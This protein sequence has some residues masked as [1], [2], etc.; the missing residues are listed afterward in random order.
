MAIGGSLI[1]MH[2]AELLQWICS[3]HKT[4]TLMLRNGSVQRTILFEKGRLV[5]TA[6]ND[7][8][9]FL[10][11]YLIEHG[12]LTQVEQESA[13]ALQ[14]ESN[15]FLGKILVMIDAITEEALIQV[16]KAKAEEELYE[17]FFWEEGDFH[18]DDHEVT[19]D[20]MIPLWMD[21]T[22]IVL[23]G[24]QRVDE[25]RRWIYETL[26]NVHGVVSE[27]A[28]ADSAHNLIVDRD[29]ADGDTEGEA[30]KRS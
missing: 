29:L 28:A 3:G 5:S 21:V 16:L 1:T 17:V 20:D 7:P 23:E 11:Q 26:P 30:T 24:A 14:R 8:R 27:D 13:M 4:G 9:H 18:F 22:R 15:I 2:P 10:G 19:V 6:S 25:A 12:V